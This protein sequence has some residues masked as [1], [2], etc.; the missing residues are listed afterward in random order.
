MSNDEQK[1]QNCT[2]NIREYY[3]HVGWTIDESGTYTD[4]HT[5]VD[6]RAIPL[7]FTHKCM[8]RLGKHFENGGRYLLDAGSGP[9][10]HDEVLSYSAAFEKRICLDF[11]MSGLR[12]AKSKLGENGICVLGDITNIPLKSGTIDAATCNHVL[13][14]VAADQQKNA[15]LELWRCLRPSGVAVVVYAWERS[16]IEQAL[17]KFARCLVR[18]RNVEPLP[19]GPELYYHAHSLK[20]FESQDWPFRYKIDTYRAVDNQF[21]RQYVGNG[22]IAQ[23]VLRLLHLLQ[24]TF[25]STCGKYGKYPAIIIYKE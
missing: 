17:K 6:G 24:T 23:L 8:K 1:D 13:Y 12:I 10:P 9:I 21:L 3:S 11:S 2:S 16:P 7:E 19:A 22:W 15:L 4:T 14:H 25:P 20:W 5:F 18:Q